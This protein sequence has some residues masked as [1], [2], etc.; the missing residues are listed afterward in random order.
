MKR[1]YDVYGFNRSTPKDSYEWPWIDKYRAKLEGRWFQYNLVNDLD[2]IIK[3]I[4]KLKPEFIIDFMGQGW[5]LK[6]GKVQKFGT[7]NLACKSKL[8]N[9]LVD[10]PNLKK[11]IRMVLQK[12]LE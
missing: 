5:L 10:A 8:M 2:S 7:P 4:A 6:A 12:C 1:K 3:H 9:S 11:Y